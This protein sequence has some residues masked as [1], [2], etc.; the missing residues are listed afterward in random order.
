MERGRRRVRRGLEQGKEG[1]IVVAHLYQANTWASTSVH[2]FVPGGVL[3]PYKCDRLTFVPVGATNRYKCEA[4]VPVGLCRA[5][6]S[7]C[8]R[9]FVS[10]GKILGTNKKRS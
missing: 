3:T 8:E 4:F 7:L 5:P 9:A 1:N 6:L 2:T 10:G